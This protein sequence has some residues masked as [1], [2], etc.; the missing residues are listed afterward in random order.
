MPLADVDAVVEKNKIRRV[1]DAVPAQRLFLRQTF[2]NGREHGRVFPD[3]RM[4]GHAGFRVEGTPANADFSTVVWQKR[5]SI[6]KP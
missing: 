6:P 1:V 4:A 2:A 5:Q 3:L